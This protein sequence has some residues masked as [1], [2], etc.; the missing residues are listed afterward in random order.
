MLEAQ[1]TWEYQGFKFFVKSFAQIGPWRF[2]SGLVQ[3]PN[4]GNRFHFTFPEDWVKEHWHRIE[5]RE[6][7]RAKQQS[8]VINE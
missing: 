1:E 3:Y 5:T 7:Y 2:A 6:Q 4:D 8:R